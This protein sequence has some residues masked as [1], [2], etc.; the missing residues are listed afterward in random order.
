MVSTYNSSKLAI[1]DGVQHRLLALESAW[2]AFLVAYC[3][4]AAC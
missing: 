4:G 2:S 1:R 3:H